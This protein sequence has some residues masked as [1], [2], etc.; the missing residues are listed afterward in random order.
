MRNLDIKSIIKRVDRYDIQK[1]FI[2]KEAIKVLEL[3]NEQIIHDRDSLR[4]LVSNQFSHADML[5]IKNFRNLLLQYLHDNEAK[6]LAQKMR[7]NISNDNVYKKL[8]NAHFNKN[9]ANEKILFEFFNVT[10]PKQLESEN[11]HKSIDSINVKRKL[12]DYQRIAAGSIFEYLTKDKKRCILHMPTGSGKTTTA[13][14][15][16]GSFFLKSN[17][18]RVIWLAHNEE[19]C[20][21]AIDEFRNTWKHI[22]DRDMSIIRFFGNHSPD[23]LDCTKKE[24]D[25]FI[26]AGL[27]KINKAEKNQ[28]M[29]LTTLADRITL[30]VMDEAHQAPAPTYKMI[31]EQLIEKRPGYIALLGLSATPGR[32]EHYSVAGTKD[33]ARLFDHKKVLLKT[34]ADNPVEY[35]IKKGYTAHPNIKIIKSDR[36][37]TSDEL[38]RINAHS[39]DMPKEILEELGKDSKRNLKIIIE[40][41]NLIKSGH[42]RIIFFG[43]SRRGSMDISLILFARGHMSFHID[44]ETPSTRR[45]QCVKEYRSDIDKPIIMC[46]FGVFTTGFDAPRTS[47]TVIARPTKS[48]VLYSQMVGRAMR[49]PLVGGNKECDICIIT[50][51]NLEIFSSIV[52]NFFKWEDIW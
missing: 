20:E 51:I 25:V 6:E 49:G 1:Y 10:L 44:G 5:Q 28:D 3:L 33:L 24:K 46:N 4:E 23:I 34:G 48:T 26:V 43:P 41:E 15:V 21:Q 7:L 11:M 52:N 27:S 45:E 47:A 19:L 16:V 22:G 39:T 14:R 42:K 35:L 38:K 29:F 50:D 2:S 17:S 8:L 36:K 31:L 32:T 13:I 30:V 18:A 12:F 9:S 40:I 37:I